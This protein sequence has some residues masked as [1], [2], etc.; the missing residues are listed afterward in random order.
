MSRQRKS[1]A[2]LTIKA[3]VISIERDVVLQD[4]LN[5]FKKLKNLY[6]LAESKRNN[7][8]ENI[9]KLKLFKYIF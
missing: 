7:Q 5:K 9:E 3:Q 4:S 1:Y 8:T 6:L 2:D